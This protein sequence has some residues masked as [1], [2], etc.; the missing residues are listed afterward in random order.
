LPLPPIPIANT[1]A[2]AASSLPSGLASVSIIF[3][4]FVKFSLFVVCL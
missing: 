4:L 2:T 3:C 1:G